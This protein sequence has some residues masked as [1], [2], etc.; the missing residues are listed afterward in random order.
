MNF[1][2]RKNRKGDGITFYYDFG[3]GQG[4]RSTTGIFIY[5]RPKDQVKKN[6]NKEALA[7][8]IA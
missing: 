1:L 5:A 2:K 7:F 6:H 8:A 3:R 4:Q